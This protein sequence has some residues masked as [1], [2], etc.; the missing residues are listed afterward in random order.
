[1]VEYL[2]LHTLNF[3]SPYVSAVIFFCCSSW[4]LVIDTGEKNYQGSH[5]S[6]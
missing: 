4:K 3:S 5:C 1:M 2:I 6:T